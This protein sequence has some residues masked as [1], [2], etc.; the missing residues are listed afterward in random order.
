MEGPTKPAERP[1]DG[2]PESERARDGR[3]VSAAVSSVAAPRCLL[4]TASQWPTHAALARLLAESGFEVTLLGPSRSM[5]GSRYVDMHVVTPVDASDVTD[6]LREHLRETAPRYTRVV[7]C[8]EEV[9]RLAAQRCS[10]DELAGWYPVPP[11]RAALIASKEAFLAAAARAGVPTTQT[12]LCATRDDV[13]AGVASLGFPLVAKPAHGH[14]GLAIVRLDSDD[15]VDALDDAAWPLLLQPLLIGTPGTAEV[16][17]VRGEPVRWFVSEMIDCFPAPFGPSSARRIIDMPQLEP[18]LRAIGRAT[19]FDGIGGVD[20]FFDRRSGR[21][22]VLE[23]NPRPQTCYDLLPQTRSAFARTL[24]QLAHGKP[25]TP[26]GVIS[27]TN[28]ETIAQ[29]PQHLYFALF[30]PRL[31]LRERAERS[32]ATLRR[33]DRSDPSVARAHA[34]DLARW[35]YAASPLAPLVRRAKQSA[36]GQRLKARLRG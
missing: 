21:I 19:G 13:R 15:D 29:Y 6:R 27:V 36:F 35:I 33:I 31:P 11:E 10:A 2:A 14:G 23:L 28:T 9:L 4:V 8:D 17:F 25:V 7:V 3:A 30:Q 26:S 24:A 1:D 5:G 12:L 32:L 16:L 22:V 20:W 18:A 34:A